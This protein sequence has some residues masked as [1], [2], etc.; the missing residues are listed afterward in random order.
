MA[1]VNWRK[2]DCDICLAVTL[3]GAAVASGVVILILGAMGV[4]VMAQV[5]LFFVV[6]AILG[7]IADGLCAARV[8]AAHDMANVASASEAAA[9]VD[10]A[11]PAESDDGASNAAEA[12]KQAAEA[13]AA[14]DARIAAEKA[15][16][17]AKAA[18]EV[19]AKKA[20]EE[21][22]AAE[23]KAATE[24]AAEKA[25][26]E[27]AAAEAKA[28][29]EARARQEAEAE[30]KDIDRDGDGVSEG[31]EEGT[32]PEALDGP[33]DGAADDLKR[34]KGI[35]PKLEKLC[36]ALG[37]YHFD[38]IAGWTSNEVAW[39]DSNLEG[40]KGRVTRDEWV[41]QAK[42]LA[43]GGQTEFSKR[44]DEGDVPSSQ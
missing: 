18:E 9:S 33:R 7:W 8:H 17:D 40:F 41:A 32:R 28:A 42:L 13:Q 20:A 39:V 35:G 22:A 43:A 11:S 38:Q 37:F 10:T 2:Y 14:N 6:W 29:A 36:N 27:Q 3:A 21:Q 19:A 16:A 24:A 25:A 1:D 23:A 34:I 44:V 15:A 12:A 31:T 30:A 5:I 4:G 26:E